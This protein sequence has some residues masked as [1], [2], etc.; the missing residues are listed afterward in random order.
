MERELQCLRGKRIVFIGDS[1]MRYEYLTLA[2]FAEYG[3]WEWMHDEPL[4]RMHGPKGFS[5]GPNPL[6][7]KYG[8]DVPYVGGPAGSVAIRAKNGCIKPY[9]VDHNVSWE[10]FYRYTSSLLSGEQCDC[11]R[12]V[13]C[14]GTTENRRYAAAPT[15]PAAGLELVFLQFFG[16]GGQSGV[17]HQDVGGTV[18]LH[19]LLSNVSPPCP[20]GQTLR[21]PK[22]GIGS[23][24]WTWR[25]GVPDVL[26]VLAALPDGRR[27]THV[28]FQAGLWPTRGLDDDYWS[29]VAAV[30]AAAV[31]GGERPLV[32]WRSNPGLGYGPGPRPNWTCDMHGNGVQACNTPGPGMGF[33]DARGMVNAFAFQANMRQE[34]ALHLDKRHLRPRTLVAQARALLR[35]VLC[36]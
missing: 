21:R 12:D 31:A 34:D 17:G 5:T 35:V 26:R 36:G 23:R 28:I 6:F 30:S 10:S 20:P 18:G 8:R 19:S 22:P 33:Y 3:G 13:C 24:H 1:T 16:D 11:F 15:A 25:M 7:E 14:A 9:R 2:L 32:W 29:H 4:V 27:P